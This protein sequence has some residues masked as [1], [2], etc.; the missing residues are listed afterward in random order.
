MILIFFHLKYEFLAKW[1]I[2]VKKVHFLCK[3]MNVITKKGLQM[4][5]Y[6]V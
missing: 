2:N 1:R 6:V 4:V 5:T 3:K